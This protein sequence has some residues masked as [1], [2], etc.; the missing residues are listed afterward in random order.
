MLSVKNGH[1]TYRCC[2]LI[3]P[4]LVHVAAGLSQA[5]EPSTTFRASSVESNIQLDRAPVFQPPSKIWQH[6]FDPGFQ[7]ETDGTY[8]GGLGS[9]SGAPVGGIDVGRFQMPTPWSTVRYGL[10]GMVGDGQGMGGGEVGLRLHPS[11]RLAPYLGL[12][13]M[14]EVSGFSKQSRYNRYYYDSNGHRRNS[15]AWGYYPTGVAAIVPEVGVSYWMTSS[16]RLNVGLSYYVTTG[17]LPDFVAA[18]VSVDFALS[19]VGP[20]PTAYP[21]RNGIDDAESEPYF[22]S[23]KTVPEDDLKLDHHSTNSSA[24]V[25]QPAIAAGTVDDALPRPL[26]ST[27]ELPDPEPLPSSNR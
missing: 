19:P 26:F 10:I 17:K 25:D 18:A 12:S 22:V 2:L 6:L 8:W 13:G 16:A 20:S 21:S 4:L 15:P 3:G 9:L 24:S 27:D 1:P 7:E 23:E 14:V 11:T 5:Q